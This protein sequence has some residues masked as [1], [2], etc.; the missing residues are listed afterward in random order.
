MP[1]CQLNGAIAPGQFKRRRYRTPIPTT[2]CPRMP[3]PDLA[4]TSNAPRSD[5]DGPGLRNTLLYID[6]TLIDVAGVPDRL[7]AD[8]ADL[9]SL[10][11]SIARHGQQAPVLVRPHPGGAERFEIVYGCLRVRALRDLGPQPRNR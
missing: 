3:K 5:T 6:S 1:S 7:D 2:E 4:L 9:E 11:A 10:K 8:L